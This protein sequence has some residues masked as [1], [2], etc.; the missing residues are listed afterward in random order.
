MEA[1]VVHPEEGGPFPGVIL[2]MD[3]WGMREV[4]RDL[5]RRVATV[6]YCC[7]LPDGYHRFGRV[8][9]SDTELQRQRVSFADLAPE[10]QVLLRESMERLTDAMVLED[11]RALLEFA[12][13]DA[14]LA[15]GPL[16][17]IGWCMGGR[18]ALC[19][20][21]SFPERV[22]ASACLHGTDL[23]QGRGDSP[24]LL[25]RAARGEL[26]CGHAQ[27]DRYAP[28]GVAEALRRSLAGCA[29][30][31][32]DRVHAGAQHGYAI[33][34]RDVHDKQ[35]ANRDWERIFAMFRRQLPFGAAQGSA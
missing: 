3:M 22:R 20:A 8:R 26:Y 27:K 28:A 6:G 32:G 21:G 7:L 30:R 23:V 13:G 15:Q 9:Y 18:H 17:A 33:P 2:Y 25:A 31:F 35:A 10:R 1:F 29:L 19:A 34:D 5:A 11:T 4:L 24:H 16:G 14:A 12:G